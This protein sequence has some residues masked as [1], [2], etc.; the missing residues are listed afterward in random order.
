M[1]R[2]IDHHLAHARAAAS[3]AMP[4]ARTSLVES[5]DGLVR[6]VRRLYADKALAIDVSVGA[7]SAVRVHRHD[8]DEMLGNLLD[9]ACKWATT[10]VRL[11]STVTETAVIVIR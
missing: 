1:R 11:E 3:G 9:N 7:D 8:L 5:T 6:T 2:Q 4:G 10:R